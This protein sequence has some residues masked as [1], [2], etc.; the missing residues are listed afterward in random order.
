MQKCRTCKYV[1]KDKKEMEFCTFCGYGACENCA[2]KKRPFPMS[3]IKNGLHE[4]RDKICKLCDRKFYIKKIVE[5]TK[6]K[7]D[8]NDSNIGASKMIV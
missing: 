3:E 5:K 8:A 7:M 1:F 4:K 2:K 6:V